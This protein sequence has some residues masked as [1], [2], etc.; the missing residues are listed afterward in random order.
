MDTRK[1]GRAKEEAAAG[2]LKEQGAK[3]LFRNFRSRMGEIDIIASDHGICCFIEVKYRR[4]VSKGY[5]AEAVG[6]RKQMTICR[7]ADYYRMKMAL[8]EDMAYRFDVISI[9]GADIV[10]HKDA[11]SYIPY[12]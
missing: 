11:F 2:F 1:V 8:P 10:W 12:R 9:T 7:V 5:P 3:I 4:S 6:I